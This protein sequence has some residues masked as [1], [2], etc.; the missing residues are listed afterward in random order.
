M[1][2]SAVELW[3]QTA[4]P[5]A[6]VFERLGR[7]WQLGLVNAW[8]DLEREGKQLPPLPRFLVSH[9]RRRLERMLEERP[10]SFVIVTPG[11]EDMKKFV[12]EVAS[13]RNDYPMAGFAVADPNRRHSLERV[14]QECGIH[15]VVSTPRD[16]R[17]L[18]LWLAW[19]LRRI[20]PLLANPRLQ[21]WDHLPWSQWGSHEGIK[22]CDD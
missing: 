22:T 8:H 1:A 18:A 2:V 21:I 20:S 16:S 15:C 7:M 12:L 9:D 3:W 19:H 5:P 6:V 11:Q 14:V 17:A 13:L 4:G 10:G